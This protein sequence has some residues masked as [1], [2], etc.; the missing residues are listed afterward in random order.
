MVKVDTLFFCGLDQILLPQTTSAG[1]KFLDEYYI[2]KDA[3]KISELILPYESAIG[4]LEKD[5][6]KEEGRAVIYRKNSIDYKSLNLEEISKNLSRMLIDDMLAV[7]NL[8]AALWMVKDSACYFDRA[9]IVATL[10]G[11]AIVNNNTWCSRPSCSD[12]S[13]QHVSFSSEEFK[14]ARRACQ[15]LGVYLEGE[16]TATL[17]SRESLRFQRF[18]YFIAAARANNDVAMKIAFYCSALEALVSTSQQELSHQVSERV[19][20]LLVGPGQKRIKLYKR[21]KKAYGFRSKT[22]HGASFKKG[23]IESLRDCSSDVDSICRALYYLY[24]DSASSFRSAVDRTDE[25]ATEFFTGMV[26]G[27]ENTKDYIDLGSDI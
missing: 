15:P 27:Q 9:W 5:Y 11:K 17:L 6:L 4:S 21:V 2:T 16:E 14:N 24:F 10:N 22:V 1:E 26:L 23:E 25:A 20:A 8:D 13:F 3:K 19:A 18:E 12:G 7:K